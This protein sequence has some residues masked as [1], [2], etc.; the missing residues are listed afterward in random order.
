MTFIS[1]KMDLMMSQSSGIS[2]E[3]LNVFLLCVVFYGFDPGIHHHE[4]RHHE[5]DDIFGSLFSNHLK[6][7]S[8]QIVTASGG[9]CLSLFLAAQNGWISMLVHFSHPQVFMIPRGNVWVCFF[10][11]HHSVKTNFPEVLEFHNFS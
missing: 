5:R 10:C 4:I 1:K 7:K 11:S 2:Y 8:Q 3:S 9:F 6:G